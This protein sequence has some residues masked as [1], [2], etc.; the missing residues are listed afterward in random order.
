MACPLVADGETDSSNGAS[1]HFRNKKKEYLKSKINELAK[2]SKNK[3]LR[4]LCRGIN[5][6]R[7]SANVEITL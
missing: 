6:L 1:R 3:N 7:G 5:E 2:N 4:D